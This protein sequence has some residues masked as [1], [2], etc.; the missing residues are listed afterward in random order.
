MGITPKELNQAVD[1]MTNAIRSSAHVDGFALDE[2]AEILRDPSWGA[3]MLED[4]ADIVNDTGRTTDN[5]PDNRPAW[6]RH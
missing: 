6:D 3:G 4:I 1:D 2:I 5:Y